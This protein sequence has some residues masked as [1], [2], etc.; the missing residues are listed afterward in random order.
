MQR[1]RSANSK[2]SFEHKKITTRLSI[3]EILSL[4]F[5]EGSNKRKKEAA[6]YV[7]NVLHSKPDRK[8]SRKEI[9]RIQRELSNTI[10][11]ATFYRMLN[12]LMDI[13][14]IRFDRDLSLYFLSTNFASALER[15]AKAY[16][17]WYSKKGK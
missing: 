16:R 14:I 9:A 13:G 15:L 8:L 5:P 4:I 10:S 1:G 3:E 2:I 6:L 17:K 12:D 7:I 11:K